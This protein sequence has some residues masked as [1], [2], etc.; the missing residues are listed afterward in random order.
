MNLP[1]GMQVAFALKQADTG[2]SV[3]EVTRKKGISDVTFEG[4]GINAER[5]ISF[6]ACGLEG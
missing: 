6:K 1:V 2:T 3:A 4:F 5:S